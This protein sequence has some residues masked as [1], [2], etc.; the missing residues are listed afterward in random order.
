MRMWGVDPRL[1]CDQHL[2]GEHVEMH[3]FVGSIRRGVSM[4]GYVDKGLVDTEEIKARHD[5]LAAELERR[6]FKHR[7]PLEYHDELHEGR[8][9]T[10]ESKEELKRRCEK[11]RARM[12]QYE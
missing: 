1:M 2:L 12:V 10:E 4:R 9:D 11:C 3:M 6:G 7:S 8:V 5:A